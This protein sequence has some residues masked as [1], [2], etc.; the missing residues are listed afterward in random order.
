MADTM[1]RRWF[2]TINNE[3]RSL[4]ELSE[5]V[6]NLEHF[7][8]SMFQ[9]EEGEKK[10]TPHI[11]MLLIFTVGKRFSTIQN[12]FPK[13]HIEEVKGTNAQ[14]RAYCSKQETRIEGPIEIGNFAEERSRTDISNFLELIHLNTSHKELESLYPA[15]YSKMCR[16]IDYIK[17]KG[18]ED[19]YKEK[20]RDIEVTYLYGP[21]GVGKTSYVINKHSL[22]DIFTV[23]FY[24]YGN[25][26]SYNG[27]D[28]IVF[29]EFASQI[30]IPLMNKLLDIYPMELPSRFNNKTVCYT[31]VYI[32][33]NLPI[34]E[35][36]KND[37]EN[38]LY[39]AFY[40]RIH[41][42]L[43]MDE[44]HQIHVEKETKFR[45]IDKG[46]K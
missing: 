33:S 44:N 24:R 37:R 16:N 32:I 38:G 7:K 35:Q 45:L 17:E 34:C 23:P 9:R 28:V 31:K 39:N 10:H 20:L 27:Q 12:Y 22:K 40:R 11:Q 18:R 41:N 3:E 30:E 5:Y 21:P 42:I 8:Y 6:K 19:E 15:L 14:A 26:D 2:L 36:Y 25:F 1:K 4:E 29:D 46:E 13:A 43:R